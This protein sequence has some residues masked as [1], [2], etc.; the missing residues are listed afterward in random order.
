MKKFGIGDSLF[1][2]AFLLFLLLLLCH[3][4][5][6]IMAQSVDFSN[7]A[8]CSPQQISFNTDVRTKYLGIWG[9]NP[10]VPST[11]WLKGTNKF[12]GV[13][14]IGN[15][16]DAFTENNWHPLRVP[17]QIMVGTINRF[18]VHNWGTESDWNIHISPSPDFESLITTALERIYA[19]T[20]EWSRTADGRYTIEAEIT[21]PTYGRNNPWFNNINEQ[22]YLLNKQVGVYGSFVAERLHGY[23]PEIHPSEQLW[24][25]ENDNTTVLLLVADASFRF[26]DMSDYS[27]QGSIGNPKPW[28]LSK[29]QESLIKIPFSV[30]PNRQATAYSIINLMGRQGYYGSA[31]YPDVTSGTT[32]AISY[33]G[34]DVLTVFESSELGQYVGIGFEDVCFNASQNLLQGFIILKT[35]IGNGGDYNQGFVAMQI[36]RKEFAAGETPA[37]LR[38]NITEGNNS[39]QVYNQPYRNEVAFG[40]IVSSDK[41]GKGYVDGFIDFNGN[42]IT[43]LFVIKDGRWMAM[44]DAKGDWVEINSSS[45]PL[46]SLRFGDINGDQ[47][48]DIMS[49]SPQKKVRVSYSG[50]SLW[51]DITDAGDQTNDFRVGDFNGDNRTDILYM[52]LMSVDQN[53]F[54]LVFHYNMYVKYSAAGNWVLLENDFQ[55]AG[56]SEY[57][58]NFRFGNF[59]GDNITD[60]FRLSGSNFYVYWNGRGDRQVLCNLQAQYSNLNHFIFIDDH[61]R[62]RYTDVVYVQP[63]TNVWNFYYGGRRITPGRNITYNNKAEVV[64][65]KTV[66]NGLVTPLALG[67]AS[68]FPRA[69]DMALPMVSQVKMEP[70]ILPEW[71]KGSLK[72]VQADGSSLWQYNMEL[73]YYPGINPVRY[74]L[75]NPP[76]ISAV[77]ETRTGNAL[78]F[79]AISSVQENGPGKKIARVSSVPLTATGGKVQVK[80]REIDEPF[81]IEQPPLTVG[82]QAKLLGEQD[83]GEGNWAVWKDFLQPQAKKIYRPLLITAPANVQKIKTI[84]VQAYPFYAV[85]EKDEAVLAEQSALTQELNSAAYETNESRKTELFGSNKIFSVEWNLVLKNLGTGATET[86]AQSKINLN[87][88]KWKN[89]VLEYNFP[90]DG[91]LYQL[92]AEAEAVDVMGN[93]SAK[94]QVFHFYNQKIIFTDDAAQIAGWARSASLNK[95]AQIS[96]QQKVRDLQSKSYSP[97]DLLQFVK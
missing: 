61:S 36:D 24:W 49:V 71:Q 73:V 30:N 86:V 79:S 72:R 66:A 45:I 87:D 58:D 59:N 50:T 51:Q 25:K 17:K 62:N 91:N 38:G 13:L 47:R 84:K 7:C 97:I 26:D 70:Y 48:T 77:N 53:R 41:T 22:T 78:N 28:S 57:N 60:I 32:H 3:L 14:D 54:P 15:V 56:A 42:G 83:A 4:P 2:K 46:E 68:Y 34:R 18:G 89:D 8:N 31:S 75:Q 76:N 69:S 43:D 29:A 40:D 20:D 63:G 88:G 1:V 92:T 52:K 82:I 93:R 67:K 35:A 5:S 95:R 37:L 94:K 65:A 12:G 23:R 64:F 90:N 11:Y 10:G 74:R 21:P 27:E 44:Y 6:S 19:N 9:T 80:L 55:L 96:L 39:W 33:R 85:L 16:V 81:T